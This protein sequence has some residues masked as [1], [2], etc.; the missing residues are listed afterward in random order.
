M[1]Q[2]ALNRDVLDAGELESR[3]GSQA[4]ETLILDTRALDLLVLLAP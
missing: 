4:G 3:G 2:C 1:S